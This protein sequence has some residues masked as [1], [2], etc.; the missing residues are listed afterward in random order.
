M[1]SGFLHLPDGRCFARNWAMFDRVLVAV[2]NQ[3][4]PEPAARRLKAWLLERIPGEDDVPEI[5]YGAWLRESDN[6]LFVRSLDLRRMSPE[7]HPLLCEAAKRAA[8]AGDEDE[9][10]RASL[11][12]LADLVERYERGEPPLSKSSL[13]DVL[14]PEEGAIGPEHPERP[15]ED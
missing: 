12:F 5:G 9:H 8:R 1:A 3:L 6:V 10:L 4:G 7:Y 2:A 15:L 13:V 14:P 11:A